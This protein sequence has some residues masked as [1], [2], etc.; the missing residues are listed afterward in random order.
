MAGGAARAIADAV[1]VG[2]GIVG[3]SAA[4]Q[5]ASTGRRVVLVE[6]TGIAAG[7]SGRNSGVVQHPFDPVL[8]DLHL[9]TL[10][11]YRGLEAFSIPEAP[12]G[13]LL[14]THDGDGARRF[15]AEV[16]ATHPHL[17]PTYVP[18]EEMASLE[19]VVAP[20]VAA[21]RL[22]IGYPVAPAAA[23]MAFADRAR[24]LGVE[25]RLGEGAGLW[26][27]GGRAAGVELVSGERI[28]AADV[29]VAAGPWTPTIVDPSGAWRPISA[30]WGVVVS[31]DLPDA[32]RHVLEE[33][34]IS[35]E[36]GADAEGMG[37]SF[38]LVTADGV[39]SLGSTF[40]DDEPDPDALV[41]AL[42]ERGTTFVPS[43]ATAELGQARRCARPLSI[44][45]RPLVGGVPG[46]ERLWVAA[47]HGPWGISTGPASGRLVADLI[48]GRI[49]AA[50][51]A[52][53][54]GRFPAP[55]V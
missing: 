10:S 51:P 35:I 27:D 19:P 38:S 8:V 21:C 20:G 48:D 54:P 18:P 25:I 16:L 9:E 24:I 55:Q 4:A 3:V 17:R 45:G 40:L 37:M 46:I 6:R 23:T 1:I 47:G 14:V 26:W 11:L 44:D 28:A 15:S 39:A 53:D 2:G 7:A 52:L 32:P 50:P 13:L 12:V 42:I 36:P 34:E 29:V 41:P 31:I 33:A 43:I 30:N 5:L 22:D 49:K